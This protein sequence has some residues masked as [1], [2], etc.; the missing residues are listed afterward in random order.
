M[1]SKGDKKQR[2]TDGMSLSQVKKGSDCNTL[3]CA[4]TPTTPTGIAQKIINAVTAA[5]MIYCRMIIC[6][7]GTARFFHMMSCGRTPM[8]LGD[9]DRPW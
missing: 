3:I 2:L 5:Y 1:V 4:T 7:H 9:M 8:C 6:H